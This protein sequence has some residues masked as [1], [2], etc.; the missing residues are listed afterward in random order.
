MLQAGQMV[1]LGAVLYRVEHVNASRAYIVP[2]AKRHVVL[3]DGSEFDSTDRKGVSISPDSLVE[4]VNDVARAR[5]EV[6]LEEAE[7]A[8]RALKARLAE[9][10]RIARGGEEARA[11]RVAREAGKAQAIKE[12]DAADKE[13]KARLA[14]AQAEVRAA[15]R[16]K[17]TWCM[18]PGRGETYEPGSLKAEVTTFLTS[19]AGAGTAEVAA[20]CSGTLGAVTACL[21]RFWK[22]GVVIKG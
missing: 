5:D 19:H 6:E 9:E 16:S 21:D 7:S 22:A 4:I 12:A 14:K 13:L 1:K 10:E 20:A 15:G 17:H 18:A 11:R 3:A 8:V 2:L